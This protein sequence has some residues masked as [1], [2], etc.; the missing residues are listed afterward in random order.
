M[1]H[2]STKRLTGGIYQ[3]IV[4][5]LRSFMNIY[6]AQSSIISTFSIMILTPIKKLV[7]F[8][9]TLHLFIAKSRS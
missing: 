8:I 7:V 2:S 3:L 4:S 1:K 6:F 9:M 5:Y